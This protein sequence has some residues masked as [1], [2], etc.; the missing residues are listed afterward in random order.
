MDKNVL[1]LGGGVAGL[2]AASSLRDI[3]YRVTLI[4]KDE[5]P[6]GYL[7]K[8]DRLY[9]GNISASS[10]I[11]GYL[12]NSHGIRILTNTTVK[13]VHK[14]DKFLTVITSSSEEIK[15]S[16][17]IITT[18]FSLFDARIKEEYGYGLYDRVIT[19]AD[20]ES[21]FISGEIHR[22]EKPSRVGFVHCV[23]SRDDKVCNRH[24]SK[25]CCM[26]AVKQACEL[27]EIWPETE[28]FCFYMDLRMF[29]RGYEDLYY[30]A[31]NKYGVN[32]IRGRV[33]EVGED[34]KGKLV[35][36]A[37]DTL[38]SRPLKISLDMLVLMSGMVKNPD[39]KTLSAIFETS[40]GEDGF[41]AQP[42]PIVNSTGSSSTRIFFAGSATGPKS[43]AESVNEAKSAALSVHMLLSKE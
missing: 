1:I 3:G 26:T 23:G 16:A 37:E 43:V 32:F 34:E 12:S 10:V 39:N 9:P 40:V 27:K 2:Q 7:N 36:K 22:R 17:V 33:S 38:T 35:V 18:G 4:E 13:S 20:L 5:K 6:G 8:W 31:Q 11:E 14:S 21:L 24:C 19:N 42:H 30:E 28:A 25:I 15:A 29:G 41:F